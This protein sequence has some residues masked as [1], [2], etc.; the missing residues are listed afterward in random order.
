MYTKVRRM[1]KVVVLPNT[2]FVVFGVL[3]AFPSSDRKVPLLLVKWFYCCVMEHRFSLLW[4]DCDLV[5]SAFLDTS[6]VLFLCVGLIRLH[7]SG[8]YQ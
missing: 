2:P 5:S 7:W 3:V 8:A 6:R 4:F 1:C